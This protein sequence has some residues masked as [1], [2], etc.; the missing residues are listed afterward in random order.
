MKQSEKLTNLVV[1]KILENK[2]WTKDYLRQM[3]EEWTT[4]EKKRCLGMDK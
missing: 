4:N 2:E 3:V 1:D